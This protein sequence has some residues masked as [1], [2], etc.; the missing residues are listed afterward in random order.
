MDED[1]LLPGAED[2]VWLSREVLGV[3]PV[4]VAHAVDEGSDQHFGLHA[5]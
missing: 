5:G 1:D 2:E 3:E 4:A